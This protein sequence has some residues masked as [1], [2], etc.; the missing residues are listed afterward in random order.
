MSVEVDRFNDSDVEIQVEQD[1]FDLAVAERTRANAW[2]DTSTWSGGTAA[3]RRGFQR[4]RDAKTAFSD[5]DQVA[6]GSI[7]LE[8]GET[9]HVG[10]LPVFTED[11]D[12]LV[13]SW[14][15]EKGALYNQASYSDPRGLTA[16]RAIVAPRN[17]VLSV[18]DT[19]FADVQAKVAELRGESK[20]DDALLS[21]LESS[22]DGSMS[23]IA[24]TIQAAQDRIIRSDK[25]QLLVVQGGPGTGKTAVAL[26]RV[27]WLLYNFPEEL[28]ATDILVVGPNPTFTRYIRQVLPSLGDENVV[29]K[30]LKNL[31][32]PGITAV[33]SY[34]DATAE[35]KGS[36]IMLDLLAT[37]LDDRIREPVDPV[38]LR[39]RNSGRSVDLDQRA[40]SERIRQLRSEIYVSGRSMLRDF[41][42]ELAGIELKLLAGTTA[43]E[44]LDSKALD[45]ATDRMWPQLSAQQFLRELLGSK[46]RLLRAAPMQFLAADIET[47]H[48]PSADKVSDEPWT[49]AD[50]ALL[51]EANELLRGE[52]ELFGHIVVDEAQDLSEMQLAAIRRRSR[53]GAMTIVGDIAQ[54][55][56]PHASDD[57]ESTKSSLSSNLPVNEATLEHG[58]R[59]PREVFEVALPVLKVAAPGVTPPRIVRDSGV[60]PRFTSVDEGQFH[61]ALV[62]VIRE[63]A[64][65]GRSVGVI[66]RLEQWPEIREELK[67]TDSKWGESISGQLTSAIN[68][69]TPE[70]SKGL[71]FDAVVVVDPQDIL[72]MPRGERFLYIALT[73]TTTFLDVIY[74][75][76]RLPKIFDTESTESESSPQLQ[77]DMSGF[78]ETVTE[79]EQGIEQ[80]ESLTGSHA[81]AATEPTSGR[82]EETVV[83]SIA[84]P[85]ATAPSQSTQESLTPPAAV[86]LSGAA[87][88]GVQ[89]NARIL[90]DELV[91][92]SPAKHWESVVAELARLIE[93]SR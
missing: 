85:K 65:S 57:W 32:S 3:E 23:D 26:H 1:F 64:A 69:V 52:P 44:M 24:S 11:R 47:L 21:S 51:D 18:V 42:V 89:S 36:A 22:R 72:N 56:G 55:T 73:R 27:S 81:E 78:R 87:L 39:L 60:Q 2:T 15:S 48:R 59:V 76:G 90:L 6:H 17:K 30:A 91:E 88:R 62:E 71:E 16:K 82:L 5:D 50:L 84:T 14:Q 8:D 45:S 66:A 12:A 86:R 40:V 9:Y 4:I 38:T 83:P 77:G 28:K 33:G 29:Q 93:E 25:D 7:T 67:A 43:A 20:P 79:A 34:N 10:K 58:Y 92:I 80:P 46:E 68:L 75:S 19:I 53:T 49:I 54:S 41:L 61:E 74:P 70:D 37:A 31:L 35:L 13:V 63:H